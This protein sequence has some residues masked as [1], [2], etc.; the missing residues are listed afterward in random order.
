[1]SLFRIGWKIYADVQ[2]DL[3][4]IDFIPVFHRWIRERTFDGPLLD[5]ADY[6]HV[7]HGPGVLLAA[8]DANYCMDVGHGRLG[9]M[10]YNKRAREESSG[11]ALARGVRRVLEVASRL[12]QEPELKGRLRFRA[13][14][15]LAFANDRLLAPNDEAGWA[16]L[17]PDLDAVAARLYPEGHRLERDA[18]ERERL[19]AT[20]WTDSHHTLEQLITRA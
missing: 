20:V 19:A 8:Y 16:A 15:L 5:V 9:L 1:M 14:P 13:S 11:Q 12:E 3:P 7:H 6:S 4:L 17:R 10:W 18:E 2:G